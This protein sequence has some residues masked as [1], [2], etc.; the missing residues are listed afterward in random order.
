[1]HALL[2][3]S[4]L[5]FNRLM[6]FLYKQLVHII[7]I[8]CVCM[9]FVCLLYVYLGRL[10]FTQL[11]YTELFCRLIILSALRQQDNNFVFHYY[12]HYCYLLLVGSP[13]NILHTTDAM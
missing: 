10:C 5:A 1:M 6:L 13:A 11:Q 3:V 8:I 4:L 9:L 7:I 12:Y 2:T